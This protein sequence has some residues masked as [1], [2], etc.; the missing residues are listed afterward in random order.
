MDSVRQ[1]FFIKRFIWIY[2][3]KNIVVEN[4]KIGYNK[5]IN[6]SVMNC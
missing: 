1:N 6:V 3:M 5:L 4:N 2:V